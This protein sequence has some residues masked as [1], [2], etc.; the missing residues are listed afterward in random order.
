MTVIANKI[1]TEGKTP[2]ISTPV[3]PPKQSRIP[4]GDIYTN[5]ITAHTATPPEP[6]KTIVKNNRL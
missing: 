2:P 6:P 1:I 4:N 3:S 5:G